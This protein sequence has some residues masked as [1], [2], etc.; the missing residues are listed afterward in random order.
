MSTRA[1][2]GT[3]HPSGRYLA[4]RIHHDGY[5]RAVVPS[6]TAIVHH[7]HGGDL[8]AA[9]AALTA[10]H[11]SGLR[12]PAALTGPGN[13][14]G[15][16]S[17][18]PDPPLAGCLADEHRGDQEWAYLI[19]GHRIHGYLLVPRPRYRLAF[20]AIHCWHVHE[21]PAIT[22]AEL[23]AVQRAGYARR[24]TERNTITGERR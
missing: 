14:I 18:F 15:T 16:P 3:E 20:V 2:I 12:H 17:E 19:S 21:L 10:T 24:R 9:V 5:P 11:W 7:V 8:T 23:A 13:A 1:L 22:D 4:R 6:L